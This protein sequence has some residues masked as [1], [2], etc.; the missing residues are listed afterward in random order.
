MSHNYIGVFYFCYLK[1]ESYK[2][3]NEMILSA[4]VISQWN[5]LHIDLGSINLG[6]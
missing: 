3:V 6:T 2:R 4:M 5:F 1:G